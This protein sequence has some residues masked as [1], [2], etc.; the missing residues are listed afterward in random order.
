M[1]RQGLSRKAW[2]RAINALLWYP[3]NKTELCTP[4]ADWDGCRMALVRR[5]VEAVEAAV[6][7]LPIDQRIIIKRRF[8]DVEKGQGIYRKP[9]QY[10]FLQDV[11]FSER[12]MRRVSRATILL[13]AS[14]LGER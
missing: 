13:V 7:A 11:G 5:E 10:D 6:E 8:W 14:Y 12:T 3:D 9:R 4:P 1:G 2:Q